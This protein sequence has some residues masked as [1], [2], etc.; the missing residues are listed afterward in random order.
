M[1]TIDGLYNNLRE[2]N[3][4]EESDLLLETKTKKHWNLKTVIKINDDDCFDWNS[5]DEVTRDYLKKDNRIMEIDY[6]EVEKYLDKVIIE[7]YNQKL[8]IL[9]FLKNNKE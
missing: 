2:L 6:K 9:D 8:K 4:Y 7:R 3:C 5:I 1:Y